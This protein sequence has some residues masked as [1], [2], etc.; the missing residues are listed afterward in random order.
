[1]SDLV[2][3]WVPWFLFRLGQ[4]IFARNRL[5]RHDG[6]LSILRA[7]RQA[8]ARLARQ[9]GLPNPRVYTHWPWRMILV[10]DK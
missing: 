9:A 8:L 1:M 3:G 5:T 2:R 10:V 6:A 4:P 7:Y